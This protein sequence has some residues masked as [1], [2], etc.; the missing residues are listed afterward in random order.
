MAERIGRHF[1][2]QHGLRPTQ[3]ARRRVVEKRLGSFR[4]QMF[5][6]LKEA[7]LRR[8]LHGEKPVFRYTH[9]QQSVL[10]Q[11]REQRQRWRN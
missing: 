8:G 9:C 3:D 10:I 6:Q 5:G 2:F 4:R 11:L 1:G 7:G